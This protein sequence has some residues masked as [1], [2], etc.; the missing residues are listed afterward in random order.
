MSTL[1]P[2]TKN[3]V[4]RLLGEPNSDLSTKS[5]W[6]YGKKG[7]LA[8]EIAGGN[9]GQWFDHEAKV[10]GGIVDL[11]EREKGFSNGEVWGWLETE[12]GIK[13][14]SKWA[15]TGT[16]VYRDRSGRPLYRVVRRDADGHPK[17]IH[18]E[19]YDEA[20]GRFIGE[21][22]C[23]KRIRL[24]PYRLNEWVDE[25][26]P[27]LI[28]EGE[29]KIDEL[30]KLGWLG[31]CNAGGAGKFS[32]GF[33]PYFGDRDVVIL[34]DNDAAGR[35]HAR[36]VV[37]IL[38]PVATSIRVLELPGLP[39]KGDFVDWLAAGGTADQL[40][41]LI[42]AAPP[43]D[44]VIAMW[45]PKR[46]GEGED[47]AVEPVVDNNV[48]RLASLQPVD[49][50]KVR[51]QEAK[52]LGV[53]ASTLDSEVE[54]H[55]AAADTGE[56]DTEGKGR[57]LD[58]YDPEPWHEP[59]VGSNL[60]TDLV[61]QIERFVI[62]SN[63]AALGAALWIVHAH[64]HDAA[65]HSPRL[66]L[67]S[68]TMR[69][70]KSTMLRTLARLIPRPLTTANITPAALFRVVEA[71]KPSLLI[72]E[73]DSF[74]HENEELRGVV[75]SSHCRLDA[76][77]VRAVAVGDDYEAR[78]FSTWAPMA[79]AS[80]GKVASTIADRSIM[81]PMERKVPGQKVERMRVDQDQGFIALGRKVARWVQDND[82]K[83]RSIEPDVPAALNDRQA[84]NWRP[85][86]AIADIVGGDWPRRAR[87]AALGLSTA[88]EDAET[89][90]VQ[91][92][93]DIKE[94]MATRESI[95]TEDLLKRLHAMQ[96]RPWCEYGRQ[97]KP[98]SPRQLAALLKP[99][100]ITVTQVWQKGE[101]KRGYTVEQ[102]SAAWTRYLPASPL[103]AK[104]PATHSDFLSAR[105]N[106]G[107]ADRTP[108][109][110]T[111]TAGS[112][113]L[114]DRNPVQGRREEIEL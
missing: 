86:I 100:G 66:T 40:R 97:R 58:L 96:E 14:E 19:R 5:E 29:R 92:L 9:A 8:I 46:E 76:F 90:G 99:F 83:L 26:G 15:T 3:I 114:A 42:D 67:T 113:A 69:C 87:D 7:S 112:S 16:Y 54:K 107:L 48:I 95:W 11:I 51:K 38:E 52:R 72:D 65:F 36:Q 43:A 70:G 23:M 57:A 59:V 12:I 74:A 106:D 68:P 88:D 28:A 6:R 105:G 109:K 32:R 41:K 60:I 17:R 78:R 21:K 45:A 82:A 25:D 71:A 84:D 4:R 34:P 91:L 111:A 20:S 104:E 2:H 93:G 50:D 18:Q 27:V 101:N 47:A 85:L 53:R 1:A 10:G 110:A 56:P 102:F 89:I 49:Y 62:L 55:R 22:G 81:I 30:M 75:N 24:V 79:I 44:D 64:A 73:A 63:H 80:I 77:V 33:A 37:E 61:A 35:G 39:P 31:T 94:V 108:P 13:T 103:D 98:I